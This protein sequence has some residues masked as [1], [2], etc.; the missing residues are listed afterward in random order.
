M[1]IRFQR[2]TVQV[3]RVIDLPLAHGI[4][5]SWK[6]GKSGQVKGEA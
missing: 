4:V 3:Q 6:N 1:S 2:K 5:E